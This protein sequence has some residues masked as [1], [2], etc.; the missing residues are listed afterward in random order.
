MAGRRFFFSA[1]SGEGTGA[2]NRIFCSSFSAYIYICLTMLLMDE[3]ALHERDLLKRI[4][5]GDE[6]AF[7]MIFDHYKD[8]F[9]AAALKMTR[10]S[11][12]AEE[13]VQDVFV[14]L[15]L[16]RT[17]LSEVQ[18]PSA[19][20]L[21]IVHNNIKKHFRK[22]ALEKKLKQGVTWRMAE[23]ESP[24]EDI[25]ADKENRQILNDI[26]QHLPPQQQLV[27][28][29]SR[30]EGFSRDEIADQLHISPNTV[31]NHL[32]KALKY[33]RSHFNRALSLLACLL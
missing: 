32:L 19:Y 1:F 11:D 5:R 15:W 18:Y 24:T 26:I 29:L 30:Q 23:S 14:T 8:R 2:A 7:R 16:Q 27:Y 31:K 22:L 17:A 12:I 13:T 3:N 33:I 10:S 20:L 21:A 25:L 9:F 4:A 28:Q 6:K